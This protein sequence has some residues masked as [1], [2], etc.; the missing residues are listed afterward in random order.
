MSDLRDESGIMPWKETT[1]I[2]ERT[3]FALSSLQAGV[4]F[5]ELCA[6]Y[7]ISRRTGYKWKQRYLDEGASAMLDQSRRPTTSPNQLTELELC[8]IA[9]LHERHK[10]WGPKKI[11]KLYSD[12]YTPAPSQSTFKRVFDRCGWVKKR[13]R[14]KS[15]ATGRLSS[16]LKAE[17]CNDVWTVDFKGWW[18]TGN[19]QRCEPLTVRD[20]HSRFVL[21]VQSMQT[22]RTE[23]VREVFEHLFKTYG[24]PKAIRSDNGSPFASSSAV[25]GLSR[26]SAWW[27]A[28][29]IDLERGRPGKPQDNGPH[30]RMHLDIR[31][32][33]ECHTQEDLETQQ[34]AFEIWTH[35]FNHERPHEALGMQCPADVYKPSIRKYSGT[36]EDIVYPGKIA[37]L[38]NSGGWISLH[39]HK[40]P[41]STALKGWSVG[42]L[43]T[44]NDTYDVFFARLRIGVIEKSTASFIGVTSDPNEAS[45]S[46]R[47]K[48]K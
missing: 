6:R 14:R 18:R 23:A 25:L 45:Q 38:V 11:H 47:T 10:K 2:N 43:P 3:E 36:P 13:P 39:G 22:T 12:R 48:T 42:L 28:L 33:L 27:V 26:L 15:S 19:G 21:K 32:E 24:L 17:D 5:T 29:G 8:R 46:P 35:T 4:N 41:I 16:G 9:R 7:G 31:N 1:M 40:F 20:E 30:E 34:A 44:C 37:R